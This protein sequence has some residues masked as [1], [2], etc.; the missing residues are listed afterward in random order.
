M[1]LRLTPEIYGFLIV[2]PG[3]VFNGNA[4]QFQ[5]FYF[6][7]DTAGISRKIAVFADYTMTGN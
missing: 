2:S 7:R 1:S 4:F 3:S 6:I 5:E